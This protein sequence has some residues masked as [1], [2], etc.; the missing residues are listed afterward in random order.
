MKKHQTL[1]DVNKEIET[2]RN[3]LSEQEKEKIRKEN[4]DEEWW[5]KNE[6]KITAIVIGCSVGVTAIGLHYLA[7]KSWSNLRFFTTEATLILPQLAFLG[8]LRFAAEF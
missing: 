2:W 6:Y 3:G 8:F 7:P 5:I 1:E 4:E